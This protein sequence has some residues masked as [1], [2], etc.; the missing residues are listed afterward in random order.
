MNNISKKFASFVQSI[1]K[2]TVRLALVCFGILLPLATS[3]QG[4]DRFVEF[5]TLHP[6]W[7]AAQRDSLLYPSKLILTPLV[8]FSPETSLEFGVGA[9]YLFKFRK[10]GPET[11]TSNMPLSLTYTLNNQILLFSGFEIFSNQEKYMLTGNARF[12]VFPQR[13]YGLGRDSPESAEE[14]YSFSQLLLEPIF[15]KQV[16]FRHL[17][18]GAG[19]RYNR[20]SNVTFEAESALATSD[21]SGANGS[22]SVGTELALV[23][24]SRDNILTAHRGWYTELTHGFYGEVLGGTHQFQL[25]RLDIRKFIPLARRQTLAFQFLASFSFQ[26]VPLAE[27]SALGGDDIMRGYYAGRYLDNHF[28][29]LQAEYRFRLYQRLGA[30]VFAGGGDVAH[31]VRDF[32]FGNIRPH[33]G[34]RLTL[35]Y[36]YDR[37]PQPAFRLRLRATHPKLLSSVG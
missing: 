25:T 18:L 29:A 32:N 3:A 10:S 31:H 13:F 14:E 1:S 16:G 34:G 35:S 20:V 17:F 11:R 5:F 28:M 6:N 36:R 37:R 23:Y 22:T 19:V 15:L 26:D 8:A 7:E 33:G 2:K 27:L 4:L 30:V 21:I 9:K 24:D 12:K